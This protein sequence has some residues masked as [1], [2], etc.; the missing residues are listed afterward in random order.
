MIENLHYVKDLGYRSQTRAG[1]GTL[2]TNSAS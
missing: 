1:G 2:R